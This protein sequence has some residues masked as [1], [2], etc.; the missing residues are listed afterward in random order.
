MIVQKKLFGKET[1]KRQL[2]LNLKSVDM[3]F[4]QNDIE[5]ILNAS[6]LY[7][8]QNVKIFSDGKINIFNNAIINNHLGF[9]SISS[10]K[11]L[12]KFVL[13]SL[14]FK[15]LFL[16]NIL[17]PFTG[18][19]KV[20]CNKCIIIHDRNS[21]GYFHW[22]ND[23]LPKLYFIEKEKKIS[24]ILILLPQTLNKKYVVESLKLFKLNYKFIKNNE[25]ILSKKCFYI[26]D[27][28]NSG[29][30]RPDILL[31]LRDKIRSK[32]KLNKKS[33]KRVY[34]SRRYS[35]RCL[36][37]E[38]LVE[39]FLKKKKFKILYMEKLSF[40]QQMNYSA[41]ADIMVGPYGAGL[42]NCIFLK[43]G[44]KILEIKPDNDLYANCFFSTSS[45]LKLKYY[46]ILSKKNNFFRST[47][48]ANY[49]IEIENL[50]NEI[51]KIL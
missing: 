11:I 28:S 30:P 2:P 31:G 6:F 25:L 17:F 38:K 49:W 18:H 8:I 42:I 3:R 23:I 46:Y 47:K 21:V 20:F 40:F 43:K 16:K 32:I 35:R 36:V 50:K 34:I 22:I 7:K 19:N 24:K 51:L 39:N 4:F 9:E 10:F 41:N 27:I 48:T 37:N 45:I 12:K 14:Y 33:F 13:K 44:S 15:D 29:N 26:G 1:V 5:K